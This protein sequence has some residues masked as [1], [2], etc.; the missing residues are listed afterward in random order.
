MES[1]LYCDTVY[2]WSEYDVW[3]VCKHLKQAGDWEIG[4]RGDRRPSYVDHGSAAGWHGVKHV[5]VI[6]VVSC[7]RNLCT[8]KPV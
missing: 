4:Y 6:F 8:A 5:L 3:R 1:S 2:S 7:L